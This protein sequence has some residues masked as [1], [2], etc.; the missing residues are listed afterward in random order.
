MDGGPGFGDRGGLGI[1]KDKKINK[2]SFQR[3]L[4]EV[5]SLKPTS[6]TTVTTKETSA[7]NPMETEIRD[8]LA[9]DIAASIEGT[10]TTSTILTNLSSER[11]RSITARKIE[12]ETREILR[13]EKEEEKKDVKQQLAVAKQD[14]MIAENAVKDAESDENEESSYTKIALLQEIKRVKRFEYLLQLKLD[15]VNDE[16]KALKSFNPYSTRAGDSD[17]E[18][19][20][21]HWK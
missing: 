16:I 4:A 18:N 2:D 19:G 20:I 8:L 1:L 21:K 3:G 10:S 7:E 12:F 5:I 15:I 13:T 6:S 11:E 14:T 17:V 9:A